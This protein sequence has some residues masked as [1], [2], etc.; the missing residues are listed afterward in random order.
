MFDR[1]FKTRRKKLIPKLVGFI[2]CN[3]NE[4]DVMIDLVCAKLRG[5]GTALIKYII[6]Y[7]QNYNKLNIKLDAATIE[8]ACKFY[9]RF[10]FLLSEGLMRSMRKDVKEVKSIKKVWILIKYLKWKKF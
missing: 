1:S 8:L 5:L 9:P 10:G 6:R 3:V 7:A 4:E 2:A